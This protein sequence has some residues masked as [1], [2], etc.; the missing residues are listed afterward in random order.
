M[1]LYPAPVPSSQLRMGNAPGQSSWPNA[2]TYIA[3]L[4]PS[5][6]VSQSGTSNVNGL[7]T[8]D[9]RI[10]NCNVGTKSLILAARPLSPCARA[11]LLA[12]RFVRRMNMLLKVS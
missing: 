1:T 5:F 4:C 12:S 8:L 11:P 7:D 10:V 6:T 3:V 2:L 9:T